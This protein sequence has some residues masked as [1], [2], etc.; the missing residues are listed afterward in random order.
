M[1]FAAPGSSASARDRTMSPST[2][3]PSGENHSPAST[4]NRSG[5][6]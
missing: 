2:W 1:T 3:P 5:C 4:T 6:S